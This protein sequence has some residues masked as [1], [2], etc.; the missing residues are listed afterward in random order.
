ML[1][2]IENKYLGRLPLLLGALIVLAVSGVL[3]FAVHAHRPEIPT[4][5]RLS[6][7]AYVIV[8]EISPCERCEKF[9]DGIGKA[10]QKSDL[11]QK[12]PIRYFDITDGPPPKRFQLRGEVY[13]VP[14]VVVFD[15]YG[16]E[17]DR[18]NGAPATLDVLTGMARAAA[19]KA[20]RDLARTAKN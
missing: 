4:G 3:A 20:E 13:T 10:Y 1:D 6:D 18:T 16:R 5:P 8:F 15:P 9:R 2:W 7:G 14:S 17:F 12:A 11:G 19:R